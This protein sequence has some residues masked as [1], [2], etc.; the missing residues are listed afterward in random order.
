MLKIISQ[1]LKTVKTLN[2]TGAQ[3]RKE[4]LRGSSGIEQ[5]SSC[6][7]ALENEVLP[8]ETRGRVRNKNT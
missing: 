8:D 2:H 3:L 5:M 6:I 4:M 7:I 1:N